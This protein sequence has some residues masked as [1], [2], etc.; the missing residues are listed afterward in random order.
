MHKKKT[1]TGFYIISFCIAAFIGMFSYM[2]AVPMILIECIC[3]AFLAAF[4]PKYIAPAAALILSVVS[5]VVYGFSMGIA[6]ISIP[7]TAGLIVGFS[8]RDK[9]TLN[10]A[11]MRSIVVFILICAA[12][13]GIYIAE[14]S[15]TSF[16]NSAEAVETFRSTVKTYTDKLYDEMSK[17]ENLDET[18]KSFL[19]MG[20]DG[21]A[22]IAF[23]NIL[24]IFI[25]F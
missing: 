24:Y 18:I 20:K 17:T 16:F 7:V 15:K 12:V 4:S 23:K 10:S 1:S 3:L 2:L 25:P 5:V 13:V 21:L 22:D 8:F 14:N 19:A 6:L 11:V 9:F